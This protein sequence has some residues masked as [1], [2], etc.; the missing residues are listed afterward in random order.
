[1]GYLGHLYCCLRRNSCDD[2]L[3]SCRKTDEG[4]RSGYQCI[5]SDSVHHSSFAYNSATTRNLSILPKARL[6]IVYI[7]RAEHL[8]WN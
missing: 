1:M 7:R 8:R 5:E 2:I 3:L 6:V 4:R